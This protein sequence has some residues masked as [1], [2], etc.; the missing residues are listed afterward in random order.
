MNTRKPAVSLCAHGVNRVH[1]KVCK[2]KVIREDKAKA[3]YDRL[4]A[5]GIV[6][7]ALK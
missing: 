3:E 4:V 6:K 5:K 1:C 7:E 2:P